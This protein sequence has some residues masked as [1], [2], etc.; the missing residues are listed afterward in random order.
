MPSNVFVQLPTPALG[1]IAPRVIVSTATEQRQFKLIRPDFTVWVP[2][3]AAILL[4]I[5]FGIAAAPLLIHEL[6]L[7]LS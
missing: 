5:G 7:L 3:A 2:L 6:P 4:L 1:Q